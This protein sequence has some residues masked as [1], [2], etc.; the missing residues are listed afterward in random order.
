MKKHT[1][2]RNLREATTEQVTLTVNKTE[3]CDETGKQ[4]S[5]S[6]Q[7]FTADSIGEIQ[8]LLHLAGMSQPNAVPTAQGEAEPTVRMLVLRAGQLHPEGC[9]CER[10]QHPPDCP[11][12]VC[13][14]GAIRVTVPDPDDTSYPGYPGSEIQESRELPPGFHEFEAGGPEDMVGI[15]FNTGDD[16]DL[17]EEAEDF[18]YGHRN[19]ARGDDTDLTTY[20]YQSG[21]AR[22]PVRYVPTNSGDN[23]LRRG[24]REED[25]I[26]GGDVEYN[27][28][29]ND[30][31]DQ[32]AGDPASLDLLARDIAEQFG[33]D[34]AEIR[35]EILNQKEA[36]GDAGATEDSEF[37]D[38]RESRRSGRTRIE[39]S[40][41]MLVD[42]RSDHFLSA[43]HKV[44]EGLYES[45]T[46]GEISNLATA[47]INLMQSPDP[48]RVARVHGQFRD[49][50]GE[51]ATLRE[52][53]RYQR[54]R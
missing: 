2:T 12:P 49:Y 51:A 18:D 42:N 38:F 4:T 14:Q 24:V 17:E 28:A 33:R 48:R 46:P 27:E 45:L 39:E 30:A 3:T 16:D 54:G 29:I 36:L 21:G 6:N 26:V 31:V 25:D 40:I 10:C 37:E 22:R 35:D 13:T 9:R 47:F 53:R 20:A 44:R 50:L 52:Y 34:E 23:P 11:C 7:T 19:Y 32:Y 43:I 15:D 8:R 5:S 41:Q 1:R